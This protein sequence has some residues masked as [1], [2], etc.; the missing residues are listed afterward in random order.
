MEHPVPCTDLSA[1]E[2]FLVGP[3]FGIVSELGLA[4]RESSEP[5][6]PFV[7]LSLVAN[8]RF[9]TKGGYLRGG[10][11]GKG[12]TIAAAR[13][14]ALGEAVERYSSLFCESDEVTFARRSD[15]PGRSLDPVQLVLYRPEQYSHVDCLPYTQ[16]TVMG[17]VRGRSLTC[18]ELVFVPAL[19]VYLGYDAKS[20]EENILRGTSNGLAAGE[21]LSKAVFSAGLEVIERD[22][23]LIGWN[24]RIIAARW[25]P[26]THP[27][28]EFRRLLKVYQRR[29]I[30]L[31]LFQMPT[32]LDV[33]VFLALG[34]SEEGQQLP[35]AVVGLGAHPDPGTAAWKA[36]LEVGQGRPGLRRRLHA[37]ESKERM[38]RLLA[39]PSLV[40]EMED[41]GLLYSH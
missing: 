29:G 7:V 10:A 32:D 22:A 3:R 41:H 27:D 16:E 38:E 26:A 39:E 17:W 14:G 31:E 12:L 19:A 9:T 20:P 30:R 28:P 1:L 15:L 4:N 21:S 25:E 11:S 2:Q 24:N 33:A 18:D 5:P 13:A 36:F 37:T 6:L 23:F 34:V 8:S 40:K 35:S